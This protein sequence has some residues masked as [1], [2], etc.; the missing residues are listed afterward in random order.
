MWLL[1]RAYTDSV[2]I[3]YQNM[4]ISLRPGMEKDRDDVIRKLVDI[5]YM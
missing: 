3:D 2:P 4:V 5:Q 1:Y